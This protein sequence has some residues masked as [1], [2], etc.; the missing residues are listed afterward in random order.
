MISVKHN[1]AA[2]SKYSNKNSGEVLDSVTLTA[3]IR[4][5][6]HLWEFGHSVSEFPKE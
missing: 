6:P 3:S 4:G 1:F 5:L 2:Q